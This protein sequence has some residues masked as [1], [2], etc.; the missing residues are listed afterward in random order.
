MSIQHREEKRQ[1]EQ[2]GQADEKRQI[3]EKPES[4]PTDTTSELM[5]HLEWA[6]FKNQVVALG[7]VLEKMRLAEYIAYL[8]H[9]RQLLWQNFLVGLVRGIG[10]FAGATIVTGIV[11]VLLKQLVVLNLPVIGKFIA[12][13]VQMVNAQTR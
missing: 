12:E 4:L 11:I 10:T 2:K 5:V 6:Q 8:N 13:L 9:P 7:E 3:E 1:T